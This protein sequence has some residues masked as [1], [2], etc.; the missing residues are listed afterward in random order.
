[1]N[2]PDVHPVRL[3]EARLPEDIALAVAWYQDPEVLH[4]SE[5]E[6]VGPYDEAVVGRM[7]EH[8][9]D[10]GT[11]FIVEVEM[12]DG[13]WHPIGDAA[14]CRDTLPIVIGDPNYRSHGY[15]RRVLALIIEQARVLGWDE[16]RVGKVFDYNE[17]SLRL[18]AGAGFEV[19]GNDVDDAG[20]P[21]TQMVLRLEDV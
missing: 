6:G 11:M 8:F 2:A 19:T 5:G 9:L 13:R 3:R 7:Y 12:G 17:R 10:R 1:M 14:L 20:R 4:F 18:Y 21:T 15:G 16:L